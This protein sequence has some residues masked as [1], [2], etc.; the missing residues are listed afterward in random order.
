VKPARASYAIIPTERVPPVHH[1]QRIV[2]VP[3]YGA[4]GKRRRGGLG[5]AMRSRVRSCGEPSMT[6][7]C[8]PA[9]VCARV[10]VKW[11]RVVRRWRV[12]VAALPFRLSRSS[13]EKEKEWVKQTGRRSVHQP[14]TSSI[15]YRTQHDGRG[16]QTYGH[17]SGSM[18]QLGSAYGAHAPVRGGAPHCSRHCALDG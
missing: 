14:A 5:S 6:T 13:P 11:G 2:C 4:R 17:P 3:A 1:Q 16:A 10:C 18:A 8:Q 7:R 12:A 9:T 15:C